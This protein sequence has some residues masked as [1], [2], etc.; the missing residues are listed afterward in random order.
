MNKFYNMIEDLA[1]N[2]KSNWIDLDEKEQLELILLYLGEEYRGDY[3]E[4]VSIP[5][6][7]LMA[8]MCYKEE[9]YSKFRKNMFD[10]LEDKFSDCIEDVLT[11][12]YEFHRFGRQEEQ[13]R[14]MDLASFNRERI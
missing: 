4:E 8:F 12:E 13:Y 10:M 7:D 5:V 2:G 14:K 9:K 1:I 6:Q 3:V 11:Q